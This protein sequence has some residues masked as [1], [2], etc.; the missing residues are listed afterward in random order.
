MNKLK[1]NFLLLFLSL[2][3]VICLKS[4]EVQE[5]TGGFSVQPI[6]EEHQK[7]KNLSY[8]WLKVGKDQKIELKLKIDNG[9]QESI[10]ELTANQAVNNQNFV[11]DYSLPKAK[12]EAFLLKEHKNFDFNQRIRFDLPKT[13][14]QTELRL[15]PGE[16]QLVSFELEL[17][18]EALKGQV[19][20]G[21]NVTRKPQEKDRKNGILNVYSQ[22]IA[23]VLEGEE[24][25]KAAKLDLALGELKPRVQTVQVKNPNQVLLEGVKIRASLKKASGQLVS[26]VK[27]PQT[28]VVPQALVPLKLEQEKPLKKGTYLLEVKAGEQTLSQ[29]LKVSPSGQVS[30]V[31]TDKFREKGLK[32]VL[33]IVGLFG[34]GMIL[35]ELARKFVHK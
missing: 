7:D 28:A 23:L 33:G 3:S 21:I 29:R 20:G 13:A 11:V 24:L 8:W 26:E 6:F 1:K 31:G 32:I 9:S 16:S 27:I 4:V 19:I 34:V 18:K 35:Y 30:K 22:T 12:A 14:K 15:S 10:L 25:A 5:N 17:P 2:L